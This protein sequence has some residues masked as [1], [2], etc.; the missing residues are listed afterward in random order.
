MR[1]FLKLF[2]FFLVFNCLI[3]CYKNLIL[4]LG[5]VMKLVNGEFSTLT[6][7]SVRKLAAKDFGGLKVEIDF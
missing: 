5:S 7:H 3:L 4:I 1:V 6:I 2:F